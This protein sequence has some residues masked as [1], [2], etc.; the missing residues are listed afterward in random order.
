ML[1]FKQ[2]YKNLVK[3][4]DVP[5]NSS[6]TFLATDFG[7][8]SPMMHMSSCEAELET[9][10][11]GSWDLSESETDSFNLKSIDCTLTHNNKSKSDFI[12]KNQTDEYGFKL[13]LDLDSNL[14]ASSASKFS[15]DKM[16]K[17]FLDWLNSKECKEAYGKYKNLH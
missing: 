4:Q 15:F 6:E 14:S 12:Y 17:N 13:N 3:K 2:Q 9:T 11:P 16:D 1:E 8:F 10:F 5:Y 7:E